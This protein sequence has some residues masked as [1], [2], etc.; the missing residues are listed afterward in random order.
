MSVIPYASWFL[1][2]E[3]PNCVFNF[4]FIALVVSEII[5]KSLI[6]IRGPCALWTPLAENFYI[7]NEYLSITNCVLVQLS[8]PSCFQANRWAQIYING[9]P[10]PPRRPERKIFDKAGTISN[11]IFKIQLRSSSSFR[12]IMGV[13]CTIGSA[14]PPPGRPLAEKF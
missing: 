14:A 3:S 6:F 13:P 2:P 8:I 11:G 4:N 10:A 7:R 5:G 12:D 9:G 1:M